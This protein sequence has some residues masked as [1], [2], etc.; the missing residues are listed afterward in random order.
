LTET[1]C[2]EFLQKSL[3]FDPKEFSVIWGAPVPT[4]SRSGVMCIAR[5]KSLWA[6]KALPFL[7][8][9]CPKFFDDGRLIL[10]QGYR[11]KGERSFLIYGIYGHAG[12]RWDADKKKQTHAML[13]AV[14]RDMVARGPQ[15]AYIIGDFNFQI[16]ES[17]PLQT[18]MRAGFLYD[19]AMWG[20]QGTVPANTCHKGAGSRIDLI[21][22]THQSSRLCQDYVVVPGFSEKDHSEI[23]IAVRIPLLAQN[24]KRIFQTG[25]RLP[26][27]DPPPDY[28]E[29]PIDS[30]SYVDD[31]LQKHQLDK[32]FDYWCVIAQKF[33]LSIPQSTKDGVMYDHGNYR[34][35]VR[36]QKQNLFPKGPDGIVKNLHSRRIASALSRAQE[37]TKVRA[38]GYMQQRTWE[39]ITAVRPS[40][41]E[42]Q[43][44]SL[45]KILTQPC[46][47]E[48]AQTVVDIL[49]NCKYS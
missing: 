20:P 14:C 36:F 12:S 11:G 9:E 3:A 46:S 5:K 38:F 45:H 37:L 24:C 10:V 26:Y 1:H 23:Q 15:I 4:K 32:A 35:K 29:K 42:T 22:M 19:A 28:I 41:P 43:W 39:N 8:P 16:D 47:H 7:E 18:Y 30:Q 21:L 6:I 25:N 27:D 13:Y 2:T 48:R 40:L 33:L 31:L 44:S 49:T 34:G 17:D